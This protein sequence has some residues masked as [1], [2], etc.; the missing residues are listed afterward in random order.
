MFAFERLV[1]IDV[2]LNVTAFKIIFTLLITN[3]GPNVCRA[4][5]LHGIEW[6]CLQR[7][8]VRVF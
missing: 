3:C 5:K 4:I 8:F 6:D 2:R 7:N 1:K